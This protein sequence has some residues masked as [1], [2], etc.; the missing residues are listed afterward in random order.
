MAFF[1]LP[2]KRLARKEGGPLVTEFTLTA[3]SQKVL[4]QM[5]ADFMAEHP[6]AKSAPAKAVGTGVAVMMIV[7]G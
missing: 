5:V 7:E 3:P 1:N 4:D 6:T 2:E